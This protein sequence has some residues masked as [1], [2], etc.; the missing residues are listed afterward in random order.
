MAKIEINIPD[1]LDKICAWPVTAYR[2]RKFGYSYR[3][4]PLGDDVWTLVEPQDY[5]LLKN[6]N[7]YLGGNGK[8]FYALRNAKIAQGKIKIISMHRQ[9]MNFP[10][11]R[12]V[13]HRN[14]H[15]LD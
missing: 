7:W 13:D 2:K 8:E 15:P 11:G 9:I 3:R 4:I 10:E 12:V 5:Y 14:N 6:F 1:W